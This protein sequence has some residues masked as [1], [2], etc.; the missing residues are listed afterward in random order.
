MRQRTVST[1]RA[2][3]SREQK[4]AFLQDRLAFIGELER[5]L[6]RQSAKFRATKLKAC[7]STSKGTQQPLSALTE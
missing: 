4:I 2:S 5:I 3:I 6:K 1:K 7:W